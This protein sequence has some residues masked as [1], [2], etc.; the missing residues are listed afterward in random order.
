[1]AKRPSPL[2]PAEAAAWLDALPPVEIKNRLVD[3]LLWQAAHGK[4]LLHSAHYFRVARYGYQP[5]ASTTEK[6]LN[7][8]RPLTQRIGN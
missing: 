7:L 2:S 6:Q 4:R 1:M 3:Y 5:R 8:L